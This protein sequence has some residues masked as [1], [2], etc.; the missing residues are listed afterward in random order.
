M[1]LKAGSQLQNGKYILEGKIGEGG[2]GITYKGIWKMEVPNPLGKTVIEYPVAIKEFFFGEYCFRDQETGEVQT[3]SEKGKELFIRF[4]EKLKKEASILLELD[5]P[6]IVNVSEVFEE[7]NTAYMVMEFIDG[8]NLKEFITK[9]SLT[10]ND[11]LRYAKQVAEA[12]QYIHGYNIIHLDVKPANI[13]IDNAGNS[14]LI[15]FGIAKQYTDT[16]LQTQAA[17]VA[18]F[19]KGY[20]PI[21]QY[22][23]NRKEKYGAYTDIYALG[24][25]LYH[26]L[27]G[28]IPTES[29]ARLSEDLVPPSRYNPDI[30]TNVE[31]A[32]LKAMELKHK[33]RFATIAEFL[34]VLNEETI[35]LETGEAVTRTVPLPSDFE[36]IETQYIIE[37]HSSSKPTQGKKTVISN[38]NTGQ[39]R[40]SEEENNRKKAKKKP[41]PPKPEKPQRTADESNNK[42]KIGV[43]GGVVILV[44]AI[45]FFLFSV[46]SKRDQIPQEENEPSI[47]AVPEVVEPEKIPVVEPEKLPI[48]EPEKLP[49]VEETKVSAP[50][51]VISESKELAP[52]PKKSQNS[53]PKEKIASTE[54]KPEVKS[55]EQ[56]AAVKKTITVNGNKYTGEVRNG[57]PDGRG[58]LTFTAHERI[59]ESD[60]KS[61]MSEPGDYLDGKWNNGELERGTLYDKSG[62]KKTTIIIGRY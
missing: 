32:I 55:P 6:N 3:K 33:D 60:M 35:S 53:A 11:V 18:T 45:A 17:T 42:L 19:S 49:V 13:L 34:A 43:I 2:F 57:K 48:V 26:C 20:S 29:A 58:R 4:K 8:G 44:L 56:A 37:P 1:E 25:T 21:E 54:N 14:K 30:P 62:N 46:L 38:I 5:H 28:E 31:R 23:V 59:S 36:E 16:G 40:S 12:L 24:A 15:D 50:D 51:N 10:M 39:D 52:E 22:A 41:K 27:T 61:T 7:N 47:V 9:N